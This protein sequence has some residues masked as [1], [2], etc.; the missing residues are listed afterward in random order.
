MKKLT[1][2]EI[3]AQERQEAI[4]KLRS[5][6]KP[7]D[8]VHTI[9]RHCSTSGMTRDISLTLGGEWDIQNITYLAAIAM[10]D[11]LVTRNGFNAIRVT[12]CGMDMGFNLVYCLSRT[13]FPEGFKPIDAGKT[14]GRNGANPDDTD[15]DGGYALNQKWL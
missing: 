1:K 7:G 11:K 10:D 14:Y 5:M 6:V 9:L 15:T 13:L 12:G 2:K 3:K 4:E 8:T